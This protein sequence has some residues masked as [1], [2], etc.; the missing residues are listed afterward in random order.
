M[1]TASA[2]VLLVVATT[3]GFVT[4]S[5]V[6]LAT[7]TEVPCTLLPIDRPLVLAVLIVAL[8]A[9]RE[10]LAAVVLA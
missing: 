1:P 2:A 4:L 5:V 6:Q 3:V 7:V 9:V 8:V 10:Q